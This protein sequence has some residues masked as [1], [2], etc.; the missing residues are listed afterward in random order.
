MLFID[1]LTLFYIYISS[2]TTLIRLRHQ[3]GSDSF[4]LKDPSN[5]LFSPFFCFQYLCCGAKETKVLVS[6]FGLYTC[7]IVWFSTLNF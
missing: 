1:N 5:V 6:V 2:D 4:S 3:M 7:I